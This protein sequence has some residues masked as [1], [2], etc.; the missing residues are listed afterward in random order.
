MKSR[1]LSYGAGMQT[2]ALL[3]NDEVLLLSFSRR[4]KGQEGLSI[5][6]TLK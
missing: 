5:K 6:E 1:F 2:F 3:V 4:R